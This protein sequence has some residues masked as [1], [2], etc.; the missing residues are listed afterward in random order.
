M[1]EKNA[2]GS[3]SLGP[4]ELDTLTMARVYLSQGKV[5]EAEA[6][7]QRLLQAARDDAV[8]IAELYESLGKSL[9]VSAQVRR[10]G[11]TAPPTLPPGYEE[12]V[13]FG[14]PLRIGAVAWCWETTARSRQSALALLQGRPGFLALRIVVVP[15]HGAQGITTMTLPVPS[16]TGERVVTFSPG[17]AFVCAAIGYVAGETFAP[18]A[19]SEPLRVYGPVPLRSEGQDAGGGA[20]FLEVEP[21]DEGSDYDPPRPRL[22]RPSSPEFSVPPVADAAAVSWEAAVG[23]V[24]PD[25][26]TTPERRRGAS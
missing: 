13:V 4:G 1:S 12:D 10:Q 23:I 21:A 24:G 11:A 14:V 22:C 7:Y 5:E 9:A 20:H 16:H 15:L 17:N 6:I 19:H 8:R 3:G 18:V 25:P 2:T 26:Q